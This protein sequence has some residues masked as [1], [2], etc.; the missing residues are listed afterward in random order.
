MAAHREEKPI[1]PGQ[2]F[3]VDRFRPDDAPGLVN[4]YTSVYGP[5]YTWECYYDPAWLVGA[6]RNGD[7]YSVVART[8]A[9]D[10]VAHG[11][12]F[13]SSPHHPNLYEGGQYVSHKAYRHTFAIHRINRHVTGPLA[14]EVGVD[15]VFGEEVC[16]QLASQKAAALGGAKD[17]AIQIDLMPAATYEREKSLTG[18]ACCCTSYI[19]YRD[20][21]QATFIPPVYREAVDGIAADLG[22]EREWRSADAG[23]P[24]E[25]ASELTVRFFDD[26]AVG[27]FNV[28]AAG[29]DFAAAVAGLEQEGAGRGTLVYQF[30]LNAGRPG[31]GPAVDILRARGYFVGGYVPR[32]F[33]SD[34]LL[35]QKV[36]SEP[37]FAAIQLY[38]D[39]ARRLL[40]FIRRDFD[41][42][43][44]EAG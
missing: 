13:R 36:L 35:M 22:L 27:R 33:D 19:S 14:R 2:T 28:V 39:K 25:A 38:T 3:A 21:P 9:G 5:H 41:R 24:G 8:P 37:D 31:I 16:H 20:R 10:I 1:A 7:L 30:F 4:L 12:L 32:W 34:G 23:A 29:A 6:N 18:R 43:R 42:A 44:R 11:A 15:G 17:C 40:D 26:A